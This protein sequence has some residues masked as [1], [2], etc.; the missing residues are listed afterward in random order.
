[1]AVISTFK[2]E[3]KTF[4]A[5]YNPLLLY[6][7]HVKYKNKFLK[8]YCTIILR[9]ITYITATLLNYLEFRQD[10]YQCNLLQ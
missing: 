4:S 7:L 5:K 9:A 6:V 8:T 1:M 3:Q 2:N 10:C